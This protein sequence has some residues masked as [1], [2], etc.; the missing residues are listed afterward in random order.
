ML[1]F[2]PYIPIQQVDLDFFKFCQSTDVFCQSIYPTNKRISVLQHL[3]KSPP[4][5][6]YLESSLEIMGKFKWQDFVP[7]N[8]ESSQWK[9]FFAS[10]PV[11]WYV[12]FL[13]F[14]QIFKS[15]QRCI[16]TVKQTPI[17][18]HKIP[19]FFLFFLL[20]NYLQ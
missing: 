15:N 7:S 1:D 20:T 13:K 12:V 6:S 11:V 18:F 16:T 14:K 9:E 19:H 17:F 5:I 2:W 3:A 4:P 10:L 8:N